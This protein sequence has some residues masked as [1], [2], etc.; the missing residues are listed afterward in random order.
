MRDKLEELRSYLYGDKRWITLLY[1]LSAIF[2]GLNCYLIYRNIYYLL[3]LP[4]ILVIIYFYLY[5]LDKILLLIVLV[6]PLAINFRQFEFNVGVSIPSEPLMLGVLLLFIIKLFFGEYPDR[7]IWNHPMTIVIGLQLAWMFITSLT[8]DL[9][10][11]SFKQFLARLWFVVPFYLLGITLFRKQRNISLFIWLYTFSFL[12]VIGYTI[13]HHAQFAF[14]EVAGHWVMEPFYNDHTIYGA[15]IA[16]LIPLFVGFV[17]QRDFSN[18]LRFFS[19]L[20]LVVLVVALVLS[21]SRAAWLSLGFVFGVLLLVLFKIKF[22]WIVMTS[23]VFGLLFYF[24]S[25]EI[26]DRLEK[27]EQG[28]SANFIEHLRSVTNIST[29]NSNLERINRWQSAFRLFGERPVFGWGPGTYQFEY[30]PY[31]RSKE[32]TLISTN[33]GDQGNAH[34]EYIGPLAEQGLP[35]MLLVLAVVLTFV[36]VGLRVY[37]HATERRIRIMS[38]SVLLSLISYFV[39]GIMNNF[40]DSDKASV[41]VWGL[42]AVLVALDLYVR[43][44]ENSPVPMQ[45]TLKS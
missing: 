25:F 28:P 19:F 15:V 11:V 17:L 30:A 40:L 5:S 37:K 4:V 16:L 26:L 1:I 34:S 29:D 39:H 24:F 9:P 18:T 21:F 45:D 7:K 44:K 8:S 22:R 36:L 41:P 33:A 14:N 13:Y 32:K 31:Q 20:V 2:I 35:G 12:I 10:M 38:L 42:I 3:F 6:T 23:A 43:E 27:N